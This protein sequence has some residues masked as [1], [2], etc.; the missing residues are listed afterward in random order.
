MLNK[1][2]P[3]DIGPKDIG[4]SEYK[5]LLHKLSGLALEKEPQVATNEPRFDAQDFIQV[6]QAQSEKQPEPAWISRPPKD[7]LRWYFAGLATD[8]SLEFALQSAKTDALRRATA[9]MANA[10]TPTYLAA[11]NLALAD[12]VLKSAEISDKHL[13]YDTDKKL[14]QAS[15]LMQV[16]RDGAQMD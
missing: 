15:I 16:S 5:D 1:G 6:V 14:F 10:F 2:V 4:Y 8:E 13:T 9:Y 3:T 11:D 12:Y 7:N